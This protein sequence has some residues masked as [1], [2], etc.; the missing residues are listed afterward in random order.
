MAARGKRLSGPVVPIWVGR[1]RRGTRES[2]V[3]DFAA[4]RVN[5][6][7]KSRT[8]QVS[9]VGDQTAAEEGD[10]D[11]RAFSIGAAGKV[12]RAEVTLEA[13]SPGIVLRRFGCLYDQLHYQ[14]SPWLGL[15]RPS[16]SSCALAISAAKP[17]M[18][19]TSPGKG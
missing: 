10:R 18:P 11:E 17:W 9:G 7:L 3:D 8:N 5:L 15:T 14:R 19:G 16:T 2:Q 12:G 6:S 1:E 4:A 13:A